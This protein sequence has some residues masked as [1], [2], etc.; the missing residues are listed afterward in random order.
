MEK[1]QQFYS[2]PDG[3]DGGAGEWWRGGAGEWWSSPAQNTTAISELLR[4][5]KPVP[6]NNTLQPTDMKMIIDS[7]HLFPFLDSVT[8]AKEPT[9][10]S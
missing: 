5:E 4:K 6:A 9:F 3:V 2:C 10:K 1:L 8:T 7:L